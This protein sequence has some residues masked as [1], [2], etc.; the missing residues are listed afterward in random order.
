VKSGFFP[1]PWGWN[2]ERHPQPFGASDS[3]TLLY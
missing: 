2:L 1:S 3:T